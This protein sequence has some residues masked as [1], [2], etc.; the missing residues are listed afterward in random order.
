MTSKKIERPESPIFA[1]LWTKVDTLNDTEPHH[2]L[3]QRKSGNLKQ[4]GQ[5]T[6]NTVGVLPPKAGIACSLGV[7]TGAGKL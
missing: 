6:P 3:M 2:S 5:S 1:N 4:Y 7:W